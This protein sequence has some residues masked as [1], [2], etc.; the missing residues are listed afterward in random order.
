MSGATTNTQDFPLSRSVVTGETMMRR[1]FTIPG[2]MLIAAVTIQSAAANDR[3]HVR[4]AHPAPIAQ[5]AR[6]ANAAI[7]PSEPSEPDWWRYATG[8][9]SAPAGR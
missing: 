1:V 6:D 9:L 5:S 2:A 7:W 3:H 4:K 8:A